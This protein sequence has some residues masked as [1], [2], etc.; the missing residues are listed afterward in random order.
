[1]NAVTNTNWEKFVRRLG[2]AA[3]NERRSVDDMDPALVSVECAG[4][5]VFVKCA[6]QVP[7]ACFC[8][9]TTTA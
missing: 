3:Y 4:F 8:S 5:W 1:M 9:Y 6:V 7:D 2:A